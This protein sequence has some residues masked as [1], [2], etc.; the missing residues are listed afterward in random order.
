MTSID[1]VVPAQ[2]K[3]GECP[4]WAPEEQ[5]LYWADIEGRC[6]HRYDPSTG[7]DEVRELPGRPGA[8]ARTHRT[9][10]FLVAIEH[11]LAWFDWQSATLTSWFDVEAPGTGN[12]MND[13]RTDPA[14]RFWVGSMFQQPSDNRFTGNLH[15]IMPSGE[16]TVIR[17]E[18]G[19]SNGLAFDPDRACMYW[20]DT[21]HDMVWRYDYEPETGAVSNEA[22]FIDF[23]NLPGR[24]DGA[25]VDADGGYWVAAVFGSAVLRFTPNGKLDR[26]IDVPVEAPT[27]PA[28]GGRDLATLFVTSIGSVASRTPTPNQR[29]DGA[30]L[31]IDVGSTGYVDPP[32]AGRLDPNS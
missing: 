20:A 8:F 24:P 16:S 30:L 26:T 5:A 27:M 3:V 18:V 7:T 17:R 12:R 25:C 28:F 4:V 13:G 19:V 32:F 2:A 6:I 9:G 22:P 29:Y 15:R 14:G 1:V 10:R 31:A 11:E 23:T 21:L